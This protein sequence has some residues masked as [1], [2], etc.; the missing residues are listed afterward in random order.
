MSWQLSVLMMAVG[1]VYG[2]KPQTKDEKADH[3]SIE[4]LIT[5]DQSK[6]NDVMCGDPKAANETPEEAVRRVYNALP[7]GIKDILDT[8]GDIIGAIDIAE[9]DQA[10][11]RGMENITLKK[12]VAQICMRILKKQNEDQRL[13]MEMRLEAIKGCWR[14]RQVAEKAR[15]EIF[16]KADVDA[17]HDSL[18]PMVI[19]GVAEMYFDSLLGK[20]FNQSGTAT[21]AALTKE[22]SDLLQFFTDFDSLRTDLAHD[23]VADLEKQELAETLAAYKKLYGENYKDSHNFQNFVLAELMDSHYCS[24]KTGQEFNADKFSKS[25][26]TFDRVINFFGDSA[27]WPSKI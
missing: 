8:Q 2:C 4:A 15:P 9:K 21:K 27:L 13:N 14:G 1:L 11:L 19:Y 20:H 24:L 3:K 16:V 10:A 23:L 22:E 7:I 25:R 12:D 17:I 18:I 6:R 26:L 5:A